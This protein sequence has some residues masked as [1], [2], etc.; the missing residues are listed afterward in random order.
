MDGNDRARL[1]DAFGT[2][3]TF[4]RAMPAKPSASELQDLVGTYVSDEAEASMSLAIADG[5]L[6]VKRRPDSTLPLTPVYRDAFSGDIGLLVIRRDEAGR[7]N[8]FSIVQG[9]VWDM[10][11]VRTATAASTS[12]H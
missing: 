3:E 4:I 5:S 10:R 6:V 1:V 11:F 12:R 9:R 2:V 8:A 7:P